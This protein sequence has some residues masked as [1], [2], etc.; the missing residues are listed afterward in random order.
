MSDAADTPD[1]SVV[2][3]WLTDAGS[4]MEASEAHGVLCGLLCARGAGE[5]RLWL[6]QVVAEGHL[7]SAGLNALYDVTVG[8]FNDAE[9]GLRLLLPDDDQPLSERAVALRRWVQGYLYGIG[10]GGLNQ[11]GLSE[12]VY[13][14]LRDLLE[15][16]KLDF[17][18]EEATDEDEAAFLEITEFVR[19]GALTVYEELN[20]AAP[21]ENSAIH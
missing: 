12:E 18:T 4:E 21:P 9:L 11:D 19:L 3:Q 8:Q 17:D 16:A 6:G 13:E 7:G 2:D 5:R 15:V 14:F 20:P 10:M 1:I